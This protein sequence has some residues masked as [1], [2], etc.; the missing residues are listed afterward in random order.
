MS[1]DGGPGTMSDGNQR[2]DDPA[3]RK[4]RYKKSLNLP[5]TA[6]PMKANLAQNEPQSQKRWQKE[7][8]YEA[9][10]AARQD[11][12]PFVF[13]D[14]P[15]YA[16]GK[17]HVGHL[18]NK[19]LKDLVVRSR[20]LAGRYCPYVPGWD[21][22]GLP[23]EHKVMTG[24]VE[25]GKAAKLAELSD[26]QRRMA[27]R[28]ECQRSA[29]K[30]QKVQAQQMKRLSTLADYDRPYMTMTGPYEGAVL[31]VFARMVENG[32]VYRDLKPV[33][34]SIANETALAEAEL[35]YRDREDSSIY[36]HFEA[37]K[38]K[39]LASVFGVELGDARVSYLIWT[40]TPWTLPANLLIAVHPRFEYALVRLGDWVTVVAAYLVDTVARVAGVEAEVLATTQGENLLGLKY[41]H[42]F[43][44]RNGRI[45][46]ADYVTLEDG[47]GLVHT[48]PG[49]GLEDYQTGLAEGTEI[50]SPVRGDG[51]FDESVPDWLR[52]VSV[53]KGN[54]LILDR[55]ETSGHLYAHHTFTHSYPH[56]WRSK[57]PVIFRC[58]E[59]WFVA[60]DE[61]LTIERA[62]GRSLRQLALEAAHEAIRFVPEWGVKRMVGMLESRPDWCISRQR[63][64]GLPI[65]AF[66]RP[67]GSILLTVAS[68]R[69]IAELFSREGSDAWFQ[70]EPV[71]LLAGYDA[72][73][74]PD[75]VVDLDLSTLTKMHDIFDVWFES[76]SSWHAAMRRRDL[77]YPIDLYLEGSDQHRG[78]FQLALLTGLGATARPPFRALLTH[79]FMVDK[80][81]RKMSKSLG[82]ALDVDELLTH[83]GADVCRWWVSS[84]AYE[85]DIKVDLSYFELA[86]ESYRKVRNT[87]RF[88]LS[89]LAD[90][91][92][93][94]HAVPLD[95]IPPTS[96][97]ARALEATADL[98]RA[99]L[100]AY[101][102]YQFRQAHLALFDFC[103]DT[104]SSFYLD[105]V[106]DR[107]YCD[108]PDSTRRRR[109]QSVLYR[110]T[111]MLSA[112]LAPI[113]PH[114]ADEAYR[115]LVR[116]PEASVHRITAPELEYRADAGWGKVLATRDRA[117]KRLEEA[118]EQGI[119]NS[120]DAGL[121]LADADGALAPFAADLADAF[122]VSRL[123]LETSADF[124]GLQL[125]D[126]RQEPR[127]ERSW[128]R[129]ET[130]RERA[131]GGW[132][133]DRDA[134]AAGIG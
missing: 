46:A 95:E 47:T 51:T 40:T 63:A 18:L 121:V 78:W 87:L 57:T 67:D 53:W 72:A 110:I 24:L 32:I 111:E 26:D 82:N 30:F 119:D 79:G 107:L 10:L 106:K 76:G 12:E 61:P 80:D 1:D 15:P 44:D 91:D 134:D 6:F 130:V 93:A 88:L 37:K 21:C 56:D 25:S 77:G 85:N 33:H 115:E 35:E 102:G 132:L 98:R 36:V 74:D 54:E 59:Q 4:K 2:V 70:K 7:G 113:L 114:T 84:L 123:R 34:W 48:A 16:N 117:L 96:L 43:V 128:R 58:T 105:A 109:T 52:G 60:V 131:D 27:V 125:E 68:V 55:L 20:L 112:L 69:A 14:G 81:G 38:R 19:V 65:P 75:G 86:G 124:D 11:G 100:G 89:N 99:V 49:H 104:L 13:H 133:S 39:R 9:A 118:K 66:R 116:N 122:G 3:A 127:C 50:Y 45:V 108:R 103:N 83:F 23:I 129:D 29:E 92:A 42:P 41:R 94:E 22:H 8:V 64:W 5:K 90:F 71:E 31:E 126:L 28:R 62:E 73:A 17:I 120:L 97:D 101:E